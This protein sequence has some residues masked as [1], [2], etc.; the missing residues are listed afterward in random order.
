MHYKQY[1]KINTI[2]FYRFHCAFFVISSFGFVLCAGSSGFITIENSDS[3]FVRWVNRCIQSGCFFL[4]RNPPDYF[5]LCTLGQFFHVGNVFDFRFS[6]AFQAFRPNGANCEICL[7]YF[8]GVI[9]QQ[10]YCL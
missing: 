6:A 4:F 2:H 3:I 7:Y 8:G 5:N 10:V 1:T 9:R